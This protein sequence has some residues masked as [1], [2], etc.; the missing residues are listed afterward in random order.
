MASCSQERP[1]GV[2]FAH[3]VSHLHCSPQ[4]WEWL[5]AGLDHWKDSLTHPLSRKGFRRMPV[6]AQ[7]T[8]A[9][10]M[11]SAQ[12]VAMG[13]KPLGRGVVLS[14]SRGSRGLAALLRE[15]QLGGPEPFEVLGPESLFP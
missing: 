8:G 6:R 15:D 4:G 9:Q 14:W 5:G 2:H 7:L 3:S 11:G 1:E 12:A 10:P 13:D